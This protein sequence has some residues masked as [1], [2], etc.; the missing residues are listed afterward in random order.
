MSKQELPSLATQ[1]LPDEVW[2]AIDP[3]SARL[4]RGTIARAIAFAAACSALLLVGGL[5]WESGVVVPNIATA[6]DYTTSYSAERAVF[7]QELTLVNDGRRAVAISSVG[8]GGGGLVLESVDGPIP[9]RLAPGESSTYR[10]NYRVTDCDRVPTGAWPV[11]VRVERSWGTATSWQHLL[12]R[13]SSESNDGR[14]YEWQRALA[15]EVCGPDENPDALYQCCA[16]TDVEGPWRV[17][18]TQLVRWVPPI[19]APEQPV[20]ADMTL[21]ASI[22]GPFDTVAE[23]KNSEGVG[24]TSYVAPDVTTGMD[25]GAPPASVFTIPVDAPTGFYSLETSVTRGGSTLSSGSVVEV[26]R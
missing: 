15:L 12:Q 24:R 1:A 5:V 6:T 25:Q 23:L 13:S 17:G 19:D 10:L 18:T 14:P 2:N 3:D 26:K 20:A 7:S 22:S 11:P 8:R 4:S 21:R 9:K 16:A